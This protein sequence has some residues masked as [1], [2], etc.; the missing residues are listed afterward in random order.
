L[1]AAGNHGA[2]VVIPT[3][4]FSVLSVAHRPLLTTNRFG[5]TVMSNTLTNAI[6]H[7][8]VQSFDGQ[9]IPWLLDQWAQRRADKVFMQWQPFSGSPQ[10]WSFSRLQYEA[11]SIAAALYE[12]GVRAGDFVIIH[13]DNSPEFVLSWF[14]CAELGAVAVSTNTHS[15]ARDMRYFCEHTDAVCVITQP[16]Y[17]EMI[18]SA[19]SALKFVVVTGETAPTEHIAFAALLAA[20]GA[21]LPKRPAEPM[22]SL[23]VQFT[24]GTTS[25]PKAVL[26]TH[27]NGLWGAKTCASH[28]RIGPEDRTLVYMPLFH[29]NAQTYSMLSTLWV[30]GMFVLQPKFS[31][32]R[33]W[34]LSLQYQLTWASMIP[35]AIKAISVQPVPQ[36]SYRFWG[37]A[38]NVPAIAQRFKL[39]MIGWWGMTETLTHGI[40]TDVDHPGP[41]GTIGRV[42][43]EYDIQIRS[44]QGQLAG[45]GERGLL[46]IRG[47]RG[48]SL[49]KEYYRN[50]AANSGAFDPQGWFETGDI[51]RQDE[52]GYL[53][54]S[55]RDKDMLKVGAE[56]VAASE[57][58][59]VVMQTGLAEECAVVAQQHAMLD[60]VPVVFVIA[61][62][63]EQVT[64]DIEA[65][66]IAYCREN[67][68]SFKVP[69]SVFI[70][71]SLPRST[72]EKIAKNVLRQGL[73]KIT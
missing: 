19:C 40:V 57:I 68:A 46:F 22:A 17:V 3:D 37:A 58:E 6:E 51:V 61:N 45:P 63:S 69:R 70:V 32:S 12:R 56:N 64:A 36:H 39:N 15:V 53:F 67:L 54:F 13:L 59:S 34:P 8:K 65:A 38:A 25:R 50:D 73:P 28:M 2:G 21:T 66:I 60:E 4:H 44:S 24:S 42:A 52:A 9:D 72:L 14:A 1:L 7:S 30:G 49:F 26:W 11:R 18:E 33:F 55:D 27:A 48:V 47:V 29:T 31:A 41:A 62:K 16:D 71:D 10:S 5:I 20:D 35:F 43:P 23:S